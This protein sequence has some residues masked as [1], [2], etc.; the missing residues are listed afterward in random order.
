MP[1][2]AQPVAL[3]FCPPSVKDLVA[4]H[5]KPNSRMTRDRNMGSGVSRV[6]P[7]RAKTWPR[8]SI[9]LIFHFTQ[10]WQEGVRGI[11]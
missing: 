3:H 11:L 9:I 1:V 8:L 10:V 2:L 5:S 4:G 7:S 6:S